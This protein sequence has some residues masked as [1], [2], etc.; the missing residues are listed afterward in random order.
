MSEK[1]KNKFSPMIGFWIMVLT[2]V[3]AVA[4][5]AIQLFCAIDYETGFYKSHFSVA[6]LNAILWA[7]IPI[8]ILVTLIGMSKRYKAGYRLNKSLTATVFLAAASVLTVIQTLGMIYSNIYFVAGGVGKDIVKITD[9]LMVILLAGSCAAF[10]ACAVDSAKGRPFGFYIVV[11]ALYMACKLMMTFMSLTTIANIS[12]NLFNILSLSSSAI[13]LCTFAKI[14]MEYAGKS[15]S[16]LLIVSA[17]C[18]AVF[19]FVY[20]IPNYILTVCD[21]LDVINVGSFADSVVSVNFDE[22]AVCV[23]A[24][25]YTGV[26]LKKGKNTGF[27]SS[28]PAGEAEDSV[29]SAEALSAENNLS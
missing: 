29:K 5:R 9:W 12:E 14:G 22:L 20:V 13:F 27:D 21:M 2:S 7:G 11:P 28:A 3:C 15:S 23:L 25:V 17:F 6:L 16:R 10:A 24:A 18:T 8:S 26:F 1:K 19:G 4:A